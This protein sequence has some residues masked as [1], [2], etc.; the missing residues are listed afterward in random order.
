[1]VWGCNTLNQAP[2]AFK[3]MLVIIAC[4]LLHN[5]GWLLTIP[6]VVH[7]VLQGDH[8]PPSYPQSNSAKHLVNVFVGVANHQKAHFHL[9]KNVTFQELP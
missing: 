9:L 7:Q 2:A 6:E 8:V 3:A 5:G 1:M 4:E